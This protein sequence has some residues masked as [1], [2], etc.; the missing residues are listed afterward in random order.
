MSN[1]MIGRKFVDGLNI[2]G[3]VSKISESDLLAQQ[4]VAKSN[5]GAVIFPENTPDFRKVL[6][7]Q[8][9]V[10]KRDMGGKEVYAFAVW[11]EKEKSDFL[12]AA[13]A[14]KALKTRRVELL[15]VH[16][17]DLLAPVIAMASKAAVSTSAPVKAKVTA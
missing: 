11:T 6:R 8:G 4:I 7:G 3:P 14:R 17:A 12:A 9:Q 10:S 1:E 2:I 5:G 16:A 13:N 15:R